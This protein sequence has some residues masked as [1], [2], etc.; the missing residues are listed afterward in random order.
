M[1]SPVME[2]LRELGDQEVVDRLKET[3][4]ELFNLRFQKATGQLQD[5]A[6]PARLRRDIARLLTILRERDLLEP[7]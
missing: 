1:A 5:T 7:Q 6:R 4:R 2:E 3:R